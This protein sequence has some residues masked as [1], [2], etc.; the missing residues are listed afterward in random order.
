MVLGN[1]QV[2]RAVVIVVSGDDGPRIFELKFVQSHVSG[3]VFPSVRTKVAEE[4]DFAFA[5]F[6]LAHGNEVHPAVVVVIEGRDAV[7]ANEITL[8]ELYIFKGFAVVVVP[9]A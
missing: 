2:G 4:F 9:E 6:R 8:W 1:E 7:S 5:L 3:D